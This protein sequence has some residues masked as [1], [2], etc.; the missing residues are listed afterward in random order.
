MYQIKFHLI[1]VIIGVFLLLG[2]KEVL[3]SDCSWE[4]SFLENIEQAD[5]IIRGKILTSH[6]KT[7]LLNLPLLE[8]E[9]FE[10]F[11]GTFDNSIIQVADNP[12]GD[13]FLVGTE[14]ILAL[15]QGENDD[16][17][18]P[19]CWDSYLRVEPLVVGNL[20]DHA[21]VVVNQRVD[22]AEF[23]NI[24][25]GKDSPSL[26]SYEDG[27]QFSLQQCK[28][29]YEPKN[30]ILHIPAVDVWNEFGYGITYEV[31]LI[32]RLPSFIFDLDLNSVKVHQQ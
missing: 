22:F 1:L 9:V 23:K 28:A 20:N 3:A 15:K 30:G 6:A 24:L 19:D 32:Q 13:I 2:S 7:T 26:I 25:Q 14:W 17:T 4:G 31:K 11:K 21:E 5:L 12:V 16:Y 27:V 10:I 18:V 8:I 29:S